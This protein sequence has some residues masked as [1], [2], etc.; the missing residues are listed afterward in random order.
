MT[1]KEHL[2][3]IVIDALNK[4]KDISPEC[5]AETLTDYLITAGVIACP[6]KLG[7]TIYTPVSLLDSYWVDENKI[8]KPAAAIIKN[9]MGYEQSI[10]FDDIGETRFLD[11]ESAYKCL[12]ELKRN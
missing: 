10:D 11:K 5:F 7:D 3:T 2:M 6:V 12:E 4:T 9:I 1:Q 8:I